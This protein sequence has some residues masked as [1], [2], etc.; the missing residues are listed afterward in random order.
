MSQGET[1]LKKM[2]SIITVGLV[3][4]SG[5]ALAS[6]ANAA[7][8]EGYKVCS[9]GNVRALGQGWGTVHA[10]VGTVSVSKYHAASNFY[11][12]TSRVTSS[13]PTGLW[14]AGATVVG[15]GEASCV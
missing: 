6:P 12:A 10:K 9:K 5:I 14:A 11:S 7:S 2:A 15:N 4:A 3:I 1:M 13:Q 8:A